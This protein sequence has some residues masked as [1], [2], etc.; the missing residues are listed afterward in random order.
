MKTKSILR[1]VQRSETR[2]MSVRVP[3]DLYLRIE[4]IRKDA[5]SKGLDFPLTNYLVGAIGD[6]VSIA[7][8]ELI[9]TRDK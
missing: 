4:S 8:K 6:A 9:A 3:G 7:E 5:L 1:P 2:T